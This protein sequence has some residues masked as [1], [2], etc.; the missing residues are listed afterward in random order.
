MHRLLI[1]TLC[2][3]VLL[4]APLAAGEIHQAAE[5][6]DLATLQALLEN[7]PDLV[8]APD[9]ARSLPLHLA[10]IRGHLEAVKLLIESGA[11]V[12][13]GDRENTTPLVCAAIGGHQEIVEYLVNQGAAITET[14]DFGQTALLAASGAGNIELVDYL[15]ANGADIHRCNNRGQG[16]LHW[17]ALVGRV[18]MLIHLLG[19]GADL[20]S[21]DN[22]GAT[23]LHSA[24]QRGYTDVAQILIDRGL[25]I[26][27]TNNFGEAPISEAVWDQTEMVQWLID[28]GA[29]VNTVSDSSR[30]PIMRAIWGNNTE[31]V[32]ALLSAGA[33]PNRS[34]HSGRIPIHAA[35]VRGNLEIVGIL[36][37]AGADVDIRE[38]HYDRTPLHFAAISGQ[39]EMVE[40]LISHGADIEAR[41]R[42]NHTPLHYAARYAHRTVADLLREKGAETESIEENYDPPALLSETPAEGEAAIWYLGHSGWG[43]RTTNHFLIFD[44]SEGPPRPDNPCLANGNVDTGELAMVLDDTKVFVFSSH[45]HGDHYDTT[46]FGW[47]GVLTDIT[48]VLGHQPEDQDGYEYL[49]PRTDGTIGDL[50]IW[51]ITS[52]DA[53]VG[54][55]IEVDGLTIFHAGDHANGEIGLHAEY[56]D[57][58]D[59][60]AGLGKSIDLAFLPITGCSLG[61]PESVREGVYY[62]LEKLQPKVFFPQHG[63]RN[64]YRYREFADAAR[65]DGF[66]VNTV[67]AENGGDSFVFEAG[68]IR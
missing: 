55:L 20:T 3:T 30:P 29:E 15:L 50:H 48:Y 17:T 5:T 18:E 64:S 42:D 1:T 41:D 61:T 59:Y 68:D 66:T 24:A 28:H 32:R 12:S 9:T 33:A 36:L 34:D 52:T 2:I 6:G 19:R 58:I 21:G 25:D 60:L 35:T 14:D 63:G 43:I 40:L 11:E 53:G 39:S 45:E 38:S 26:N 57:E 13:A 49:P 8:N 56:T 10:T 37:D 51:T 65:E 44:Y 62:A 67:C 4:G 31:A 47:R 46:I 23:P 22:E 16:V 54:Y 27:V 7:D